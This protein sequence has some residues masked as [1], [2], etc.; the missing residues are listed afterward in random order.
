VSKNNVK[1]RELN[2]LILARM[3]ER[4]TVL[5]VG[6]KLP[7]LDLTT[8]KALNTSQYPPN[9]HRSTHPSDASNRQNSSNFQY[10]SNRHSLNQNSQ[11]PQNS[12]KP[13]TSLDQPKHSNPP[14]TFQNYSNRNKI[15]RRYSLHYRRV[16]VE[17]SDDSIPEDDDEVDRQ[18][19]PSDHYDDGEIIFNP[20]NRRI[21]NQAEFLAN[22]A[23]STDHEDDSEGLE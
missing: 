15:R 16:S 1:R 22:I 10:P 8:I 4:G 21:N 2:N 13:S 20:Y 6:F 9:H 18:F 17:N 3:K 14:P 7:I 11:P 19:S 5:P 12:P 23:E